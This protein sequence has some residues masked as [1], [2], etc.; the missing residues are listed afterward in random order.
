MHRRQFLTT[1][2]GFS[3]YALLGEF[4]AQ[5]RSVSD[6]SIRAWLKR[7][8]ELAKALAQGH[9]Q[10]QTWHDAVNG[11]A[12]EVDV[13]R[14]A[15]E[16]RGADQ[17]SAGTPFGH[18]PQK[19]YL[20][21]KNE[22]GETEHFKFGTAIFSFDEHSVITPHAHRHMVS[23]HMVIE[24]KVRIRTYDRLRDDGDA[25]IL[26]PSGDV[27]AEPGHAAAMCDAKDNVHWFTPKTGQAMTFDI[28]IDGLDTGQDSYLIQPVDPLRA[29]R[30]ADGSLRAPL[31]TFAESM[32]R[33]SALD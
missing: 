12:R 24:G 25:L 5:A 23:A 26:K 17:R 22:L 1:L 32:E 15:F 10:A 28:I 18:D 14:L 8:D 7:Q 11:M 13:E 4:S 20:S 30:L 21:F 29:T 3:T 33:Y 6:P 31:L 27:V 19:R 9:I 2:T 16:L